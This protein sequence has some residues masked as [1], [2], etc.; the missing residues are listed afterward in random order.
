MKKYSL[1][2]MLLASATALIGCN[3]TQKTEVRIFAAASMTETLE[4]IEKKYE[5][6]HK[7]VDLLFNFDSSGKLK[8]QIMEGAECDLFIS[9]AQKQMNELQTAGKVNVETRLDL[10][11]NKVALVVPK[12]NPKGVTSFE[13]LKE[14]LVAK[15]QGFILAMGN[16]DVPVGQYTSKIL[17]HYGLSEA[18]LNAN[19]L[20]SYGD[21]V[22]VVT[23]QVANAAVSC[24]IVYKTDAFS[25]N[26][27]VVD[28]ATEEMCGRCLY[29][30]AVLAG[31]KV[32]EES[33][34]FLEYLK[35]S[36]AKKVFEGV[37][38]TALVG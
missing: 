35:G 25:A 17:N 20:I 37:G 12:K 10:L 13:V 3:K 4:S 21:N 31:S 22:K 15:E 1:P 24:G 2:L 11:E 19:G 7:N 23:T 8:T 32:E 16:S 26:L 5:K 34:A 9:A 36:Q 6:K 14:K 33:R 18:D 38:F 30:A 27:E 28:T 29:P